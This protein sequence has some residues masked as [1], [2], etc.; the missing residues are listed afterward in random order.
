MSINNI[1]NQE[2]KPNL[3]LNC[4]KMDQ[5]EIKNTESEPE[6]TINTTQKLQNINKKDMFNGYEVNH[7]AELAGTNEKDYNDLE[8]EGKFIYDQM[9][10][11][12]LDFV[13]TMIKPINEGGK[14]MKMNNTRHRCYVFLKKRISELNSQN[15][16]NFA[17]NINPKSLNEG[18]NK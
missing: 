9:S 6:T 16:D 8:P 13:D 3:I 5:E 14:G 18:I 1:E 17:P 2:N 7:I 10:L 11:I 4:K 15:F 12:T